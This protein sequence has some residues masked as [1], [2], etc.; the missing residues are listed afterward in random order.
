[1][2]SRR[3]ERIGIIVLLAAVLA[4]GIACQ[5]REPGAASGEH[6]AER[7]A[8]A[9]VLRPSTL[10]TAENGGFIRMTLGLTPTSR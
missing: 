10:A 6:W 9:S 7:V 8:A 2:A 4:A 5:K 1:M 3:A